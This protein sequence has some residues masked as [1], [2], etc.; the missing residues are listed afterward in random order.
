MLF[1]DCQYSMGVEPGAGCAEFSVADAEGRSKNRQFHLF[2]PKLK[3]ST[4]G[5]SLT[6]LQ[7]QSIA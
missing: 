7:V 6:A 3:T 1:Q 2:R 4:I 5:I